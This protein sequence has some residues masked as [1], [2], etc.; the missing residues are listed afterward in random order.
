MTPAVES[1][2]I[3]GAVAFVAIVGSGITTYLTLRHQRQSEEQRRQHERDM[4]LLESGLKA[5]VDFLAAAD[6]TARARQHLDVAS[7]SLDG[8]KSS[9]DQQIYDR[10]RNEWEEARDTSV[11]AFNEAQTAYAA[12]RM[13]V[14]AVADEAGRYLGLC[15]QADAHPDKSKDERQRARQEVEQAL[16]QTFEGDK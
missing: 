9:Q 8:A 16:R 5:G 13:L 6:R 7:R 3:T 2:S 14:P 4:R 15:M 11:A 1:A 10:Y 12:L